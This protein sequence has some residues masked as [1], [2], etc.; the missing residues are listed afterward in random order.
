MHE[1][2][3]RI[4][5]SYLLYILHVVIAVSENDVAALIDHIVHNTLDSLILRH[6]L[7]NDSFYFVL[8]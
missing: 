1:F 6:A 4:V 3:I 5:F 2:N 7:G 8:A